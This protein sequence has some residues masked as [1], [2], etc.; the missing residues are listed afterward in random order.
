ML[1][2]VYNV[3]I[4]SCCFLLSHRVFIKDMADQISAS[5]K[6]ICLL[7]PNFLASAWCM[8]DLHKALHEQHMRGSDGNCIILLKIAP[9]DVPT[10]INH[11]NWLDCV[12]CQDLPSE[13]IVE[14][15][16]EV[17][18]GNNIG[19]KRCM[20][21]LCEERFLQIVFHSWESCTSVS[22]PTFFQVFGRA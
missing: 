14:K 8:S 12:H 10:E 9:C 7:S 4:A 16:A 17:V 2:N 6:F 18:N 13:D 20:W 1:I 3:V 22:F 11:L 15:V 5:H 21:F 19:Q